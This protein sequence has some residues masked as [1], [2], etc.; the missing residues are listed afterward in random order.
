MA[1]FANKQEL[2]ACLDRRPMGGL[3][4][5]AQARRHLPAA[6]EEVGFDDFRGQDYEVMNRLQER[7]LGKTSEAA[8][9]ALVAV[10]LWFCSNFPGVHWR[11]LLQRD[12]AN[13][14]FAIQ[15]A[16]WVFAV[17]GK[18]CGS[19][20]AAL[21]TRARCWKTAE[22]Y[23]RAETDKGLRAWWSGSVLPRR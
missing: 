19:G 14:R 3:E 5:F 11:G 4:V 22:R 10:D 8:L 20:L 13:V 16:Y 15:A 21:I 18:N 7:L 23:L 2:L 9:W 17:S 1:G 6:V 12:R